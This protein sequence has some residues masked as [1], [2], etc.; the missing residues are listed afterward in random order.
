MYEKAI[1][2]NSEDRQEAARLLESAIPKL[3]DKKRAWDCLHG[4]ACDEDVIVK[5]LAAHA[6]GVAFAYLPNAINAYEDL[7]RLSMDSDSTVRWCAAF[8]FESAFAYFPDMTRGWIDLQ[9]LIQ[10]PDIM[11]QF[12]AI[13]SL[14]TVLSHIPDKNQAWDYLHG[15]SENHHGLIRQM[16]ALA[17]GS[18]FYYLP[19]RSKAWEDLHRLSWDLSSEVREM[20]A[21]GIALAMAYVFNKEMA[22]DDIQRLALDQDPDVRRNA[23]Y[24]IGVASAYI[25][26]RYQALNDLYLLS[27]DGDKGVRLA[28]AYT[29]GSHFSHLPD[30]DLICKCL[31]ALSQDTD[32][33]VRA[34]AYH[35]LGRAYVIKAVDA[36][37]T[38]ALKKELESAI[39][40]FEKSAQ[41]QKYSLAKFCYPFYRTYFAIIF[42]EAKEDEVKR[43]LAEARDA[44]GGSEPRDDL[45]KAVENLGRAL[46]ESQSLKSRSLQEVASELNAYRWYC[47]SAAEHMAAAEGKAPG[48]VKLM[49]ICNPLLKDRIQATI[50]EIQK[51]AELISSEINRAARSLSL[52]DPIKA[53]RS[54]MRM[55]SSLRDSCKRLSEEQGELICGILEDIEKEGDLCTVIEKIELAMAYALPA[56]RQSERRYLID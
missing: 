24:S 9:W 16:A 21:S 13:K 19:D 2:R 7:S 5:A 10:D 15:F 26:D 50:A 34:F 32:E 22:Y 46:Q 8:S 17:I 41:I 39:S 18:A 48:A 49:K 51:K 6:I 23:G 47:E 31:R 44:V 25:S 36:R 14:G 54:F 3:L 27:Q 45:L 4:L 42:K 12:I 11:V 20:A 53:H 38:D 52:D 55:A 1:S 37:E 29:L 56:M 30:R 33:G 28:I 35:S 43:Y 40:Y